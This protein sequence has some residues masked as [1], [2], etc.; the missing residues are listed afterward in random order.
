MRDASKSIVRLQ[1]QSTRKDAHEK[2]P[3]KNFTQKTVLCD[4]DLVAVHSSVI[5]VSD[6]P[7]ISVV[8]LFRIK[9]G[10]IVKMWDCG[11][12]VPQE[13]PNADGAF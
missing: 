6:A 4:G 11:M 13:M 8:H 10:K 5:R 2:S 1:S 9:G 7:E 12:E 3:N